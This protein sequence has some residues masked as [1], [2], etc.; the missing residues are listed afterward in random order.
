MRYVLVL[1]ACA[2]CQVAYAQQPVQVNVPGSL[3]VAPSGGDDYPA[4]QKALDSLAFDFVTDKQTGTL[5]L[6]GRYRISKPLVSGRPDDAYKQAVAIRG[7]G[8]ATLVY[9][10]ERTDDYL[11]RMCGAAKR[12]WGHARTL[13]DNIKLDC[14]WNCRGLLLQRQYHFQHVSNL[15]IRGARQ[16]ALDR[17]VCWMS[18]MTNIHI[19]NCIGFA[20]RDDMTEGTDIRMMRIGYCHTAI[21]A[22]DFADRNNPDAQWTATRQMI[23][24][25]GEHGYAAAT[26]KYGEAYIEDWPAPNDQT[27]QNRSESTNR[28]GELGEFK[29]Q[30]PDNERAILWI[31]GRAMCIQSL[32]LEG[33]NTGCRALIAIDNQASR[34]ITI[35]H[36]YI[37]ANRTYGEYIHWHTMN[38]DASQETQALKISQITLAHYAENRRNCDFFIRVDS[39]NRNGT[40]TASSRLIVHDLW[41]WGLSGVIYCAPGKHYGYDLRGIRTKYADGKSGNSSLRPDQWVTLAP[42]A[43]YYDDAPH[44]T[45]HQLHGH[46]YDWRK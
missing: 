19:E 9:T 33:N 1:L 15:Y 28:P 23:D 37:E 14:Q 25:E 32:A 16:S 22:D 20:F 3:Y 8:H 21:H 27:I 41:A 26:A 46:V 18:P 24:Y 7:C 38:T 35:N 12:N 17:T 42:G 2:M 6:S 36:L 11:L 40:N 34:N 44:G 13:L 45:G 31:G 4:I 30:S 29:L 39:A 5:W 10:G 43:T